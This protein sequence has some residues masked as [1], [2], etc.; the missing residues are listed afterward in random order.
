MADNEKNKFINLKTIVKLR[1]PES[2]KGKNSSLKNNSKPINQS[3]SKIIKT[4]KSKSPINRSKVSDNNNSKLLN[5]TLYDDENYTIFTS[6]KPSGSLV[7]S[8]KPISGRLINTSFITEKDLYEYSYSLIKESNILMFDRVYNENSKVD[9]MYQDHLKC[10]IS[11]L[12]QG[13][14]TCWFFFGPTDS[15]KSYTLR[16]GE[17][18]QEKGLLSKT[19]FEILNMIELSKQVNQNKNNNFGMKFSCYQVYNDVIHDLLSKDYSKEMKIGFTPNVNQNLNNNNVNFTTTSYIPTNNNQNLNKSNLSCISTISSSGGE[20]FVE[21][22]TKKEITS[23]KDLDLCLKEIVQFRKMLTQYLKVNDMKR[24]SSLVFSIILEKRENG[25]NKKLNIVEKKIQKISQLD[26]I[27]LPSSNNGLPPENEKCEVFKNIS[28]T[29]NSIVNNIVSLSNGTSP[30]L[31]SKLTYSLKQTLKIG[32][33][34]I[35]LNN[36]DP[37]E[38]PL[39][40]SFQSLKFTNWMRNQVLN[41]N[42]N[43]EMPINFEKTNSSKFMNN[44]EFNN[45]QFTVDDKEEDNKKNIN[46]NEINENYDEMEG[47]MNQRIETI[48]NVEKAKPYLN[49]EEYYRDTYSDNNQENENSKS[50]YYDN[51]NYYT[52]NQNN[53]HIVKNKSSYIN[54]D[55]TNKEKFKLSNYRDRESRND[56]NKIYSVENSKNTNVNNNNQEYIKISGEGSKLINNKQNYND[57]Y[58]QKVMNFSDKDNLKRKTERV[59]SKNSF[60]NKLENSVFNNNIELTEREIEKFRE[61]SRPKDREYKENNDRYNDKISDKFNSLKKPETYES[62]SSANIES[63]EKQLAEIERTKKEVSKYLDLIK[64]ERSNIDKK[65]SHSYEISKLI[66]ENQTLKSDNII[67]KE[68]IKSLTELNQ[69]LEDDLIRQR[70]RK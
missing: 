14:N 38:N 49:A 52:K 29:F 10:K 55:T 26:F 17:N 69:R 43:P 66:Q 6:N 30:K 28:K 70:N 5:N 61:T 37:T 24:K 68:D 54:E 34:I 59:L 9:E 23:I 50:E 63:L 3:K 13:H 12:F 35:F 21:N 20:Y 64:I 27:E 39:G 56:S 19:V 62:I 36:I 42:P 41:S 11:S 16:G 46:D 18:N 40:D 67:F 53:M 45:I 58:Y 44:T 57:N 48:G 65:S 1:E 32:S 2:F 15:G 31:E 7:C 8:N 60:S 47:N 25:E 22:L 4:T 51:S 33:S